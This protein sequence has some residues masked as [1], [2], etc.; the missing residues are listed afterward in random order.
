[1]NY[2]P[3]KA[4]SRSETGRWLRSWLATCRRGSVSASCVVKL[5]E[6]GSLLQYCR[7]RGCG[8]RPGG[9]QCSQA[10]SP[11][12][13]KRRGG[14]SSRSFER[15]GARP[16]PG[17]CRCSR[18]PTRTWRLPR[19]TSTSHATG[20]ASTSPR[21]TLTMNACSAS[22]WHIAWTRPAT[23]GT[24]H[25]PHHHAAYTRRRRVIEFEPA[26]VAQTLDEIGEAAVMQPGPSDANGPPS[27]RAGISV[28]IRSISTL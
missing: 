2:G 16:P 5:V 3:A 22:G 4:S 27:G 13:E 11:G 28:M 19:S 14:P 12:A 20:H 23:P 25:P 26:L 9:R 7:K 6:K 24:A 10:I 1:M 18:R 8:A 17:C 21:S 15:A